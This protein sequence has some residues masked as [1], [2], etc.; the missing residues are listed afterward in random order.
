[1]KAVT[2]IYPFRDKQQDNIVCWCEKC[3]ADIYSEDEIFFIHGLMMCTMCA[4][5][6]EKY[7]ITN[8]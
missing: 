5:E 2:N 8:D 7:N 3:G 6:E 4:K 1:M